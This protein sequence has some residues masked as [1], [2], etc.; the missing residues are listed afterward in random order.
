MLLND[1][2]LIEV[3]DK[4]QSEIDLSNLCSCQIVDLAVV[5]ENIDADKKELILCCIYVESLIQ[6]IIYTHDIENYGPYQE[7]IGNRKVAM[8]YHGTYEVQFR[9]MLKIPEYRT[10]FEHLKI[11]KAIDLITNQLLC[12]WSR[13]YQKLFGEEAV[14]RIRKGVEND[15]D[16]ERLVNEFH[17]LKAP[18][19]LTFG[20]QR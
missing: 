6:G 2:Y 20:L 13:R 9:M 3:F 1:L 8:I 15:P 11:E 7:A 19:D 10:F 17:F 12:K 14:Q 16:I 5:L 18:L 4:V